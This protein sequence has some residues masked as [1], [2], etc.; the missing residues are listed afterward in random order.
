MP[1]PPDP[2]NGAL[3][4]ATDVLKHDLRERLEGRPVTVAQIRESVCAVVKLLRIAGVPPETMLHR[5]KDLMHEGGLEPAGAAARLS[6]GEL[7][8]LYP[9]MVTWCIQAYYETEPDTQSID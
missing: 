2:L 6:T 3:Q 9:N 7:D 8:M 1:G 5:V 4:H